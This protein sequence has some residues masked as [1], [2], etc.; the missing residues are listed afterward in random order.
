MKFCIT[1]FIFYKYQVLYILQY[2]YY[3]HTFMYMY[4]YNIHILKTA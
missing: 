3:T 2:L 1:E 4:K